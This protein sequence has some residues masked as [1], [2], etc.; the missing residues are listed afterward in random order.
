MRR[1]TSLVLG[2][3]I[4]GLATATAQGSVSYSVAG[5]TYVQDFDSL[6]NSP[7]N[8][9]LQGAATNPRQW[10]DDTTSTFDGN[11]TTI[12]T[13]SIPG[14][15]LDHRTTVTEGGANGHQR[16]RAGSGNSGTGSFYS[17]G[18]N[19]TTDRALGDLGA[20]TLATGGDSL[21]IGL[22]LTNDTGQTLTSFTIT[23][24]GEQYR[25][26]G[27]ASAAPETMSFSYMTTGTTAANWHTAGVSNPATFVPAATFTAPVNGGTAATVLGNSAGKVADITA[28]VTGITWAPGTDLWLRWSDIQAF[29]SSTSTNIDDDALAI[30]NVR[31]SA[32]VPEPASLALLGF[33][34]AALLG[35]RRRG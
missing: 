34:A 5:S 8:T 31:F 32:A 10:A 28:T 27:G 26:D 16:F 7:T 23:Y 9:S 25:D 24:D 21:R 29:N 11:D 33:G 2:G 4:A 22:R 19:S 17:F 35:R 12:D 18:V 20:S 1:G 13:I 14:W 6:P 15:Y 3:L 30:D